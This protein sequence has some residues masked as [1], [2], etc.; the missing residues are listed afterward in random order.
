MSRT[1]TI[2]ATTVASEIRFAEQPEAGLRDRRR[3]VQLECDG[4]SYD[5]RS[6]QVLSTR[7]VVHEIELIKFICPRCGAK[8]QSLL[9]G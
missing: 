1:H 5:F 7:L 8:H 9:F 2:A 3:K 6:V 4:E